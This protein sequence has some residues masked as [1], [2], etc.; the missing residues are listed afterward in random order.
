MS[1]VIRSGWAQLAAV[2]CDALA[3]LPDEVD[4]VTAAALPLTGLTVLRLLRAGDPIAQLR[5]LLTG[6]S[7]GVG[8]YLTE[9]ASAPGASIAAVSALP[10]RAERLLALGAADVV[11]NLD[12]AT[13]PTTSP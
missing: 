1:R 2:R 10:E 6:A 13:E 3:V 11:Q 8:H 4:A 7:G 12:D 5:V 9:L